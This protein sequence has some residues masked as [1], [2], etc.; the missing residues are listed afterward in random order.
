MSGQRTTAQGFSLRSAWRWQ[1]ALIGLAV[2][3]ALLAMTAERA[4]LG[5]ILQSLGNLHAGWAA[6]ALIAY[7]TDLGLRVVRWRLLFARVAPLPVAVFAR[8]LV[9]GY[10]LNILLPARLGEL[11]RI[12]Y[13]KLRTET[14]RS[15]AIPAVLVE[16][17]MDG[18]IVLAA[19]AAG[20]AL[21]HAAGAGS[22]VLAGLI[23]GG[24][25]MVGVLVAAPFALRRVPAWITRRLPARGTESLARAHAS[26]SAMGPGVLAGAA[27]LTVVIYFAEALALAAIMKAIGAA[28]APALLLT[29]LGAAALSTLLP[30]APG[31]LG[32]YQLAY[33]LVFELFGRE[34]V[35][36]AAAATAVQA[37]LFAPV[38]LAALVLVLA[39]QRRHAAARISPPE[40]AA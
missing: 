9:V 26:L 11:A 4:S 27:C 35:L 14:R 7:C 15:A 30:T 32:S 34:P 5:A 23:G 16:R 38:V 19:L 1:Q 33:A 2:G 17:A 25:A 21:A 20:L 24:A 3:A 12:E 6:L 39:P 13:L 10:G 22:P 31:F 8:A 18:L 28:P 37:I 40:P 29:L 36:G